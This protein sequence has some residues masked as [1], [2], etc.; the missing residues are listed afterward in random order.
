MEGKWRKF[1]T[2]KLDN[3]L[4]NISMIHIE[5][6]KKVFNIAYYFTYQVPHLL[7]TRPPKTEGGAIG[8]QKTHR[9]KLS[10]GD[11]LL[12]AFLHVHESCTEFGA[13]PRRY[14]AFVYAY[15]SVY[16]HK[17]DKIGTRQNHLQVRLSCFI[18]TRTWVRILLLPET[19]MDNWMAPCT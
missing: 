9:R 2:R 6:K 13:T 15:Q 12:K 10:G 17:K 4:K 14:M 8:E 16:N 18:R 5:M 11:E 7:L 19:K 1:F 3:N